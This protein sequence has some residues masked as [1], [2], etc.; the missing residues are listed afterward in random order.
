MHSRSHAQLGHA[1]N[2][3]AMYTLHAISLEMLLPFASVKLVAHDS[4]SQHFAMQ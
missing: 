3:S 2:V 4:K 1:P